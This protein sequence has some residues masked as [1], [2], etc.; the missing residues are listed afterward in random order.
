MDHS[1]AHLAI[2]LHNPFDQERAAMMPAQKAY[3]I[4]KTIEMLREYDFHGQRRLSFEYI[5]FDG[6]NDTD[7]HLKELVR[8]LSGLHCRMN[9]IRFHQIPDSPLRG[10]SMSVIKQFNGA[11]NNAGI[12]TTTRGSRGEDI[13]AAC[14]M[15][16]G[17]EK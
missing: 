10:S 3:P 11:L 1:K 16:A 17:S 12:I 4:A 6:I 5:M 9:L 2:S 8:L 15:L 13:F 14:G 7:R